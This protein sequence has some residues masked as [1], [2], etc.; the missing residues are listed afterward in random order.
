MEE[1]FSHIALIK[2]LMD[3]GVE[4]VH[5]VPPSGTKLSIRSGPITAS[6]VRVK[7]NQRSSSSVF[8]PIQ[9]VVDRWIVRFSID[10]FPLDHCEELQPRQL[11]VRDPTARAGKGQCFDKHR[12]DACRAGLVSHTRS[13]NIIVHLLLTPCWA[14]LLNDLNKPQINASHI[15]C[16]HTMGRDIHSAAGAGFGAEQLNAQFQRP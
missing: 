4:C 5:G 1:Y 6:L 15:R 3:C 11:S 2:R 16:G 8:F 9:L 12:L 7:L 13:A 10:T 14:Q